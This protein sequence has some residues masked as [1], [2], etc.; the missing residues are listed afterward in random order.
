MSRTPA[1]TAGTEIRSVLSDLR[2]IV[3]ETA[4]A[5][6]DTPDPE[7]VHDLRVAARRAR[8]VV[9][10]LPSVFPREAVTDFRS[11]LKKI[12][13]ATG[14]C[15]DLEVWHDHLTGN[16]D[17]AGTV[18]AATVGALARRARR[19]V[20][21]SLEE[22]WFADLTDAWAELVKPGHPLWASSAA[23]DSIAAV[24]GPRIDRAHR[25]FLDRAR[26]LD[27]SG[28]VEA[29]HRVRIDAKKLRYLL[30]FFGPQVL[31]EAGRNLVISLKAVQDVLGALNDRT[32]QLS[33]LEALTVT[34]LKDPALAD[35]LEGHRSD[36]RED[37]D[38]NRRTFPDV[39]EAFI[40]QSE[41]HP[42]PEDVGP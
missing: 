42:I 41:R 6:P 27:P 23:G 38:A 35:T 37:L 40:L 26:S 14:P 24:T 28:P 19:T 9:G 1:Q 21:R 3:V 29:F 15:R 20:V 11:G 5:I 8:T 2:S 13:A 25:R 4:G 7:P 10:Q 22:P 16:D 39:L 32:V 31:G 12:G 36:L 17:G 33:A 34:V 30:E 18:L